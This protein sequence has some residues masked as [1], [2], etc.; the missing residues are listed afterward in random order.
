MSADREFADE[1]DKRNDAM[2][3]DEVD[4]VDGNFSKSF[5]YLG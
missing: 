4:D 2:D 1:E 3:V 5:E